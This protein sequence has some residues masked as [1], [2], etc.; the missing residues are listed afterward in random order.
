[1]SVVELGPAKPQHGIVGLDLDGLTVELLGFAKASS[2]E[3]VR[4]EFVMREIQQVDIARFVGEIAQQLLPDARRLA[5]RFAYFLGF[6]IVSYPG[7]QIPITVTRLL[8][9]NGLG[10]EVG[11]QLLPDSASLAESLRRFLRLT[12][13]VKQPGQV[14]VAARQAVAGVWLVRMRD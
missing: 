1:Q 12:D 11:R 13:L 14:V 8:P 4:G 10:G 5:K 6:P 2:S 3:E 9:V 7:G